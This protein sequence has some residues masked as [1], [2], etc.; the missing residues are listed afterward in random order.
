[1]MHF[2]CDQC[3]KG[4]R[5]DCDPRYAIKIEVCAA[6]SPT[7]LTDDDL[8][9]DHIE[10][11]SELLRDLEEGVESALL[12]PPRQEFRYDLC[13]DCHEKFVRDPLGK[14]LIQKLSF[15]EN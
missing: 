4:M 8:D 6:H 15:S 10:T 1:M 11:L 14:D 7:Q 5:P 13:P 12:P 2:T 3:G 9:D